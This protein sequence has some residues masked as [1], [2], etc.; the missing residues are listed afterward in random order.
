MAHSI[1]DCRTSGQ[2]RSCR[3]TGVF[4]DRTLELCQLKDQAYLTDIVLCPEPN[5]HINRLQRG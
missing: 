5:M 2:Q 3:V 4:G 1:W